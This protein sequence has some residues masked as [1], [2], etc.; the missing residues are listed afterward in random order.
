MRV[1]VDTD[2]CKGHSIC[3]GLCPEVFVVNTWGY[4][5]V[6]VDEVPVQFE[7]AVRTA[8]QQ[9]PEKAITAS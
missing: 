6:L 5:E 8:I 7:D 4:A 3:W 2:R 9:C 1:T